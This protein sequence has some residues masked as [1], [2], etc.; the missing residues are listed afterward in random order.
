MLSEEIADTVL[1]LLPALLTPR[2][3]EGEEQRGERR[4]GTPASLKAGGLLSIFKRYLRSD[5]VP[6]GP[7]NR[8]KS[9]NL[10][11]MPP[12]SG[13]VRI[14]INIGSNP[15]KVREIDN[16][17]TVSRYFFSLTYRRRVLPMSV[18]IINEHLYK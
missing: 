12:G 2:L 8:E 4:S 11:G 5:M 16:V 6:T 9:G 13:K 3:V 15:G 1:C 10:R 18:D 7:G 17:N 14:F